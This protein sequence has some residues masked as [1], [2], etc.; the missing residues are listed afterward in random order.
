MR[1][2]YIALSAVVAVGLIAGMVV[3]KRKTTAIWTDSSSCD[4]F[5]MVMNRDSMYNFISDDGNRYTFFY[6]YSD[7]MPFSEGYT[8]VKVGSA[9]IWSMIDMRL[10]R[11]K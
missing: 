2:I 9:D 10:W 3:L 5:T 8:F 1:K 11:K 4:G 6:N 7:C